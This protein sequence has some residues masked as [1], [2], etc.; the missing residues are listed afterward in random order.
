MSI[1]EILTLLCPSFA[2]TVFCCVLSSSLYFSVF[3][4][5]R[6]C[7]LDRTIS[8]ELQLGTTGYAFRITRPPPPP[9]EWGSDTTHQQEGWNY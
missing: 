7:S 2:L 3:L 5:N 6:L 8:F 1:L 9:S 4:V